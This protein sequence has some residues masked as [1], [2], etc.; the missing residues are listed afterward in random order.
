MENIVPV[1]F[2]DT[3]LEIM[4]RIVKASAQKFGCRVKID[5]NNGNRICEV[6]GSDI[7]KAIIA[8]EIISMFEP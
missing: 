5:F 7:A 1:H 8:D 3:N 6:A 4:A 2:V